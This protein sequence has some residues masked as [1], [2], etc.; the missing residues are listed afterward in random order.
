MQHIANEAGINKSLLHYYFRTKEKLFT[1]VFSY[2]FQRFVPQIQEILVSDSPVFT[3][4]ELI[5]SEYI[6][7]LMEN[8]FIPSFILH[9]INRDPDRLYEIM[10]RTGLNPRIFLDQFFCEISMGHLLPMDP[11]HLMVNIISLCVFPVAARP[12]IQRIF[13]ANDRLAYHHFLQERKTIVAQIIIQS[14][15]A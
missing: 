13:F 9:E 11:R 7:L 8:E 6:D 4:I 14:I 2:A 15:K 1:A 10:Q 12:L 5:V 3:K